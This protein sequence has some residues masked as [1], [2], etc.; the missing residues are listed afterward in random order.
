MRSA[1]IKKTS[2]DELQNQTTTTNINYIQNYVRFKKGSITKSKWWHIKVKPN[3]IT[4]NSLEKIC[5]LRIKGPGK[6]RQKRTKTLK[7]KYS[8]ILFKN[9]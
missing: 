6:I 8:I 5:D 3:K 4:R 9:N 2:Q 1:I 7:F